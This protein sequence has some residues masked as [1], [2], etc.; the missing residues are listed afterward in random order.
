MKEYRLQTGRNGYD[1]LNAV[2]KGDKEEA[3][4]ICDR[5]DKELSESQLFKKKEFIITYSEELYNYVDD[6]NRRLGG[7]KY[8]LVG[9]GDWQGISWIIKTH[10]DSDE[11]YED[12]YSLIFFRGKFRYQL[13]R[14]SGY[15]P[16]EIIWM[17][18]TKE[19]IEEVIKLKQ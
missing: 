14:C 5:I 12:Y 16:S 18:G 11:G 13:N 10:E 7:N 15:C 9:G 8:W 2:I 17:D 3:Q 1:L 19:Q 6:V 4:R